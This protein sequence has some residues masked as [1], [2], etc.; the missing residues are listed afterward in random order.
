MPQKLQ[1]LILPII[2]RNSEATHNSSMMSSFPVPYGSGD[3][4]LKTK[5]KVMGKA[6][7][8][9]GLEAAFAAKGLPDQATVL[10][11]AAADFQAS[12]GG[13]G[14]A[15]RAQVGVTNAI[16]D[17]IKTIKSAMTTFDSIYL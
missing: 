11:T 15:L 17:Y 1:T 2:P 14:T 3:E 4:E 6:I 13:R 5:A 9:V 10:T 7:T 8:D 16:P 12:E